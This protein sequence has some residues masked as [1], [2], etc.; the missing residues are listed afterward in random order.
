[1]YNFKKSKFLYLIICDNLAQRKN[2]DI[3]FFRYQLSI[4]GD[5]KA[6]VENGNVPSRSRE[7]RGAKAEDRKENGVGTGV[8]G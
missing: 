3:S 8:D 6:I 4:R 2:I 1:M 7:Q 5:R